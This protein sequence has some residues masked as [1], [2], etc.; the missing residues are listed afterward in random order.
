MAG[1]FGSLGQVK[2]LTMAN[3]IMTQAE[4]QDAGWWDVTAS[5]TTAGQKSTLRKNGASA[6]YQ[7]AALKNFYVKAHRVF[8]IDGTTIT[9]GVF[10]YADTDLGFNS[11]AALV[12]PVYWNGNNNSNF[13]SIAVT[14]DKE[15]YGGEWAIPAGKYLFV[16]P[17][18]G[19]CFIQV[20][21][22]EA[23]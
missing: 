19:T 11:G 21:G 6:G 10:G 9:A 2:Q 14:G 5:V 20:V 23:T 3:R 7:V 17:N 16:Q 12:N 13:F 22:I 4:L 18:S 15:Y 1:P 8:N